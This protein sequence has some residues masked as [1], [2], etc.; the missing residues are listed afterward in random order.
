MQANPERPQYKQQPT[1][2][3][4]NQRLND[5]DEGSNRTSD[6]DSQSR[7]TAQQ[8]QSFR[9]GTAP[10]QKDWNERGFSY[11][12]AVGQEDRQQS[13]GRNNQNQYQYQ[14]G[15][16]LRETGDKG[17]RDSFSESASVPLFD[18]RPSSPP[19][20][21]QDADGGY[22]DPQVPTPVFFTLPILQCKFTPLTHFPDRTL[23][24]KRDDKDAI[25]LACFRIFNAIFV[26]SKDIS[27]CICTL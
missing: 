8:S 18:T 6:Y 26:G 17:A 20:K 1:V 27:I 4:Y 11:G 13:T 23:H 15:P 16:E 9:N 3:D 24:T 21:R 14:S 19:Y 10:A 5:L 7:S 2:S 22:G 12:E 25:C